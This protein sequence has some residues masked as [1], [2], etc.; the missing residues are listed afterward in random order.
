M[1]DIQIIHRCHCEDR[2]Q[3]PCDAAIECGHCGEPNSNC[4]GCQHYEIHVRGESL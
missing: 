2:H 1:S 4:K 3:D